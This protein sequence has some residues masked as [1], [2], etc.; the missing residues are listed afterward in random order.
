MF[1]VNDL[2]EEM[3][4]EISKRP[5]ENVNVGQIQRHKRIHMNERHDKPLPRES[6]GKLRVPFEAIHPLWLRQH[7]EVRKDG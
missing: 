7:P 5:L 6:A 1:Q 3:D 4:V 2:F